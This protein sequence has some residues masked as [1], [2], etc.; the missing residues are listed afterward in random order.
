MSGLSHLQRV[1]AS[2]SIDQLAADW[3]VDALVRWHRADGDGSLLLRVMGIPTT[4]AK[5]RLACR[6]LWLCAAAA[7]Y[8]DVDLGMRA[9]LL[10]SAA[11]R[12]ALRKWPAWADLPEAPDHATDIERDLFRACQAAPLPTSERMLHNILQEAF[13]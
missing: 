12:F 3:L 11:S 9:R 4:A 8:G 1:I 5:R 10:C 6:D 13:T 2:R 7:R